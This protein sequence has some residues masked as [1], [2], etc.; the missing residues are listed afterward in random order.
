MSLSCL[1]LNREANLP[2]ADIE[3]EFLIELVI[4]TDS[5]KIHVHTP[6][7]DFGLEITGEGKM[8]KASLQAGTLERAD[9]E[10][11]DPILWSAI[12]QA[13]CD[14]PQIGR[15]WVVQ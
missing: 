7:G 6:Q 11:M 12:S 13:I 10:E 15:I 1:A 2:S 4:V 9:H 5:W 8:I 14:D 3:K